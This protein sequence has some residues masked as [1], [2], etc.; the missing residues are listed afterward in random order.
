MSVYQMSSREI[1]AAYV[2]DI[3][4][5]AL[6]D[7]G[8]DAIANRLMLHEQLP[9]DAAFYAAD[10]ILAYAQSAEDEEPIEPAPDQDSGEYR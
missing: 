3:S 1:Y 2:P 10:Q 9:E 5:S 7:Q 8:R 4:P 6:L